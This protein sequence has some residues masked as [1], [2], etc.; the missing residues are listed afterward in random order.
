MDP[1]KPQADLIM[2]QQE[3]EDEMTKIGAELFETKTK[4][5]VEKGIEDQTVYGTSLL[6]Q[7]LPLV[8]KQLNDLIAER[9]SGKAGRRGEA[10]KYL[11][12]FR[13]RLDAVAFIR[14]AKG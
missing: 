12:K 6:D 11:V 14:F 8:V 1:I 5:A 13:E 10:F 2:Q 3:L 9:E 7:T 4:G